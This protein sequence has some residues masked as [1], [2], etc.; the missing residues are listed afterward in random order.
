MDILVSVVL[1]LGLAFIMFSLGVGLV[2]DD[3]LRVL[4]RTVAFLTGALCQIIL[5]PVV[6]FG[7]ILAFGISGELAVGFMILAACPGGVTSN[8]IAR[9]SKA[10]VALSVSLTAV[11]SLTSMLTVPLILGFAFG[12]FMEASATSISITGTAVTMFALTVVPVLLG[13]GLRAALPG[14]MARGE[15]IL[16]RIA[17]GL[18]VLIVLAALASNW[19]LFVQNL[20]SLGPAITCLIAVLLIIGFLVPAMLRRTVMEAKT[21]SIETGIQNSTLGITVAALIGG[22]QA[23]T[24]FALPAAV[25]GILMY[26]VVLPAILW[27]RRLD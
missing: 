7:V 18:F 20:P 3:F 19:A 26:L 15:P 13:L 23:F 14:P 5:I 25:Y 10:D 6:T 17:T 21:I 11:I 27:F 8:V 24:A 2:P 22:Q 16:S 1:P 4:R 9:L 12:Y